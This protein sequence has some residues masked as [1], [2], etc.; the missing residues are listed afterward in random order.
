[1]NTNELVG[2]NIKNLTNLFSLMG[3]KQENILNNKKLYLSNSWPNRLWMPYDY[4]K[5]DL[6]EAIKIELKNDKSYIIS[7]WEHDSKLFKESIQELEIKEYEVLFE[8]VGMYLDL[9]SIEITE[10]NELDIRFIKSKRDILTWVNIAS[11]S[12]GYEIDENVI[13]KI[14]DDKNISLLLGYKNDIAVATTLLYKNSSVMGVH[15][16]GV[17]KEYRGQ[18]FAQSMMNKVINFSKENGENIMTLQSSS[19]GLKI[20]QKLGFKQ[21]FMLKNYQK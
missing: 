5:Q 10:N 7:L 21:N 3:A 17:P 14:Q 11:K 4:N 8:Q 18:R 1:M 20:Y 12:F 15:M 9:N 6:E 16:V 19:L 13:L 2:N